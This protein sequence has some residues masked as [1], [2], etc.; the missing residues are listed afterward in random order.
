MQTENLPDN[1]FPQE[2]E[3][4]G[5]VKQEFVVK[6]INVTL[7][8][9]KFNMDWWKLIIDAMGQKLLQGITC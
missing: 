9:D 7:V 1:K 2:L 5:P 8:P 3:S 6:I 4:I